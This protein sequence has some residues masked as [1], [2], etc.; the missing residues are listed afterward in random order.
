MTK[1]DVNLCL[2]AARAV[3]RVERGLAGARPRHLKKRFCHLLR[4]ATTVNERVDNPDG[5]FSYIPVT[6]SHLAL[7]GYLRQE[8]RA[9]PERAVR[10]FVQGAHQ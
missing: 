7:A 2:R 9:V 6:L 3:A 8:S 1:N 4:Y 5:T 10:E